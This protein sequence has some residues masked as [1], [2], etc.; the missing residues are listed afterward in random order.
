[1]AG[2]GRQISAGAVDF[3]LAGPLSGAWHR[4]HD[5]PPGRRPTAYRACRRDIEDGIDQMLGRHPSSQQLPALGWGPLITTLRQSDISM[6]ED[7]LIS[8]TLIV[9]FDPAVDA[10]LQ[11][12]PSRDDSEPKAGS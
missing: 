8:T 10:A 7:E 1:M 6:S 12:Q 9:E 4:L 3:T 11:V 5:R 2:D